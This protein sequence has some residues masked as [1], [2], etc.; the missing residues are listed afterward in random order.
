MIL[1]RAFDQAILALAPS[2]EARSV[3]PATFADLMTC[4][5]M[6]VWDGASGA[7]IYGDAQV[8]FAFRAWHDFEHK[9][10]RYGFMLAGE[11]AACEAQIA[12]LLRR[13]P[14]AP[15]RWLRIIRAEVIGQ[16]EHYAETGMFPMDQAAFVAAQLRG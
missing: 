9:A 16:A 7:T 10:G 3:A 4:G 8:N 12:T 1:D 11:T 5:R 13:F 2:F 15:A 6:I 14:S